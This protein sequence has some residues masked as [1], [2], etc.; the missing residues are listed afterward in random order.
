MP[1]LIVQLAI[2][3]AVAFVIGCILGRLLKG[4]KAADKIREDIVVAAAL[5]TPALDE[6]P[7][8]V[9]P[10]KEAVVEET[11]AKPVDVAVKPVIDE[12]EAEL[13]TAI[14]EPEEAQVE[15]TV[16]V[17]V[18]A[19]KPELLDAPL[20]GK[21]DALTAINGIGNA[22]EAKLNKLGIFHYAQ[23]AQWN[24]DQAGWIERN[25]GFA[26]RVTREDWIGQAAKLA[27]AASAST[28]KRSAKPK[29]TA[30]KTKASTRPKKTQA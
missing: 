17:V 29:R 19:D 28:T 30:A 8:P 27:E 25:I 15:E 23:I 13:Q 11:E 1:M 5:S 21:P 20:R 22:I 3:I 18:E 26:G 9:A 24:V 14:E 4:R 10:A 6:K 16:V 7:G 12:P 2:L